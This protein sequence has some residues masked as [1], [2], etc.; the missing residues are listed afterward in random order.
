MIASN[1][2]GLGGRQMDKENFRR[3]ELAML[4]AETPPTEPRRPDATWRD[5]TNA[6][7]IDL[8]CR[9]AEQSIL[10]SIK[11]LYHVAAV[12]EPLFILKDSDRAEYE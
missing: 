7:A 9:L 4:Q 5:R 3:A 2:G 11:R 12:G 10:L 6:E 8:P 1:E